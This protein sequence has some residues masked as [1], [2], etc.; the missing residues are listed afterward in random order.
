[1]TLAEKQ[2]QLIED[3]SLIEDRME[4]FSAIMARPDPLAPLTDEEKID[5]NRVEGCVS[6]VWLVGSCEDGVCRYRVD[7]DSSIVRGVA[8]L[9]CEMYDGQPAQEIIDTEPELIDAL[10]IGDQ[11]SPTR[12]KGMGHI[13][14]KIRSYAKSCLSD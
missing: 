10:R 7:A 2:Q 11:L 9:L 12:R 8:M 13:R 3:Y 14:E 4:R 1:M 5:A 6:M